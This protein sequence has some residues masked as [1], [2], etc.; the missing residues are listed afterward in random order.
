MLMYGRN[1]HSI[2]KYLS[3]NQN[4]LKKKNNNTLGPLRSL[5]M[6]SL[7]EGQ[8][9]SNLVFMCNLNS[10]FPFQVSYLQ[11]AEVRPRTLGGEPLFC[12]LESAT[13]SSFACCQSVSV[14]RCFYLG[15]PWWCSSKESACYCREHWFLLLQVQ[16]LV[17]EDPTCC[18]ATMPLRHSC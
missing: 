9:I 18:R 7:L 4:K 5:G 13:N 15:L 1:Q 3:S 6:T 2:R 11:V 17:Q 10:P 14:F 12:L 16:S 8:L